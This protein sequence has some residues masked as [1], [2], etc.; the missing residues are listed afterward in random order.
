MGTF[1]RFGKL[2]A[3]ACVTVSLT[4][5][6]G[7]RA[8]QVLQTKTAME[9]GPD[10]GTAPAGIVLFSD[11]KKRIFDPKCYVCHATGS[12]NF[13]SYASLMAGTS[14]DPGHP[15]TSK[16]YLRVANGTMPKNGTP[17]SVQEVSEIY[18]WILN[19]APVVEPPPPAPGPAPS[20]TP[21]PAP[22]PAP[23][24]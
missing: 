8:E 1:R 5:C 24:P 7:M 9:T 20:P 21:A 19:G 14:V 18:D 16:L 6:K 15:E 23:V 17:L 2:T 12:P 13:T 10:I 3:F 11:L 22:A 4:A